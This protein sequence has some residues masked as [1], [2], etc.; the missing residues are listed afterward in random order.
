MRSHMSDPALNKEFFQTLKFFVPVFSLAQENSFAYIYRLLQALC[1]DM[2]CS[3]TQIVIHDFQY[4]TIL[5]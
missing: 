3:S 1:V 4:L 5:A 2:N